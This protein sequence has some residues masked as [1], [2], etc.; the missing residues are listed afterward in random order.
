MKVECQ[1]RDLRVY[2]MCVSWENWM[3]IFFWVS[4]MEGGG[5]V[6]EGKERV[7]GIFDFTT[8]NARDKWW[9]GRYYDDGDRCIQAIQRMRCGI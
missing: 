3:Q 8:S 7:M 5:G 4:C 6:V 1:V 9:L 2:E